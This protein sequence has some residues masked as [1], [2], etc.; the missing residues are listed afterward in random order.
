MRQVLQSASDAV[1]VYLSPHHDDIAFSLGAWVAAHPGGVLINLFTRS[2]Y[3]AGAAKSTP[4]PQEI[5]TISALRDAEDAAFA[6]RH[7]LR[8]IN[9]G[10]A[11]PRLRGR[12]S[13]NPAGVQ[14]DCAQIRPALSAL[15]VELAA[16]GQPLRVF[17]PAAIG[18]HSNHL[19]TRTVALEVLSRQARGVP[20]CF[21]E[22]LPYASDWR[23]RRR[24]L[25]D[26]KRALGFALQR[27]WFP[28]GNG[29]LDAI[30]GYPSQHAKPVSG[31]GKFSP[32][33]LWPPVRHEALWSF[34]SG[35]SRV[36][37]LNPGAR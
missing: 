3:V 25:A 34:R 26:L 36:P 6:S 2:A 29:K 23:V 14:D 31:L 30:N 12:R 1:N 13:R 18:S 27:E 28:A 32:A 10:A 21:Y 8:R 5:E 9:L 24:G 15:L 4:S 16:G 11:E 33:A 19:A 35:S 17:V 7:A 22:D 37:R 20:F